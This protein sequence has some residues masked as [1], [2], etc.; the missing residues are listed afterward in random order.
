MSLFQTQ[1]LQEWEAN[2]HLL[3]VK[4]PTKAVPEARA[5]PLILQGVIKLIIFG[6]I[7]PAMIRL[8]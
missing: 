3:P 7:N 2:L 5:V 4:A 8:D 6:E 1:I